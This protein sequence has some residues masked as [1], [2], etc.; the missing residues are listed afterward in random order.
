M[1]LAHVLSKHG[2]LYTKAYIPCYRVLSPDYFFT[3]FSKIVS[4]SL[5]QFILLFLVL[6]KKKE[7][8]CKLLKN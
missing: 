3:H 5:L 4:K 2:L 6:Q 8:I 7:K 1:P